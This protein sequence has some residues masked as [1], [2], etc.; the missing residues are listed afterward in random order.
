MVVHQYRAFYIRHVNCYFRDLHFI[1]EKA[2][3]H[4][5]ERDYFSYLMFFV[6]NDPVSPL[7]GA[8]SLFSPGIVPGI[9]H[10]Q[11]KFRN[12]IGK[13]ICETFSICMLYSP[14]IIALL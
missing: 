12:Y 3:P 11:E 4:N 8:V 9:H 5:I 1:L 2:I 13:K 7:P 10:E 6:R 14:F